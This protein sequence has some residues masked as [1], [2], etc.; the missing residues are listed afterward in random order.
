[1]PS[2]ASP[3]VWLALNP[4]YGIAG[5]GRRASEHAGA[6]LQWRSQLSAPC[7]LPRHPSTP[8]AP[9]VATPPPPGAPT[10]ATGRVFRAAGAA[11]G[12]ALPEYDKSPPPARRFAPRFLSGPVA[13]APAGRRPRI[14][15]TWQGWLHD[16]EAPEISILGYALIG[17]LLVHSVLLAMRFHVFDARKTP[18]SAP[19]LEVSLVNAKT[20]TRPTKAEILAQANL[21]GGGNTDANRRA[22]TPLPLPPKDTTANDIAATT[23][24]AVALEQRAQ[25]LMSQLKSGATAPAPA[26]PAPESAD[27]A[28][29]VSA[30]DLTQRTLEVMRLEAQIARD[31]D[32]YQKRPKRHA[33]GA[34][35]AEYRFARYVEDWRQ[36]VERV[37]NL[38]YP[39][40]ARQFALY[41]SLILTVSIRADGSVEKVVI[42]RSS[43]QK[44][45][46][47]AAAKIVEMA[48]PYAPFPPD[49]RRDTDILEITRTWTFEKG[50]ELRSD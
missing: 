38:N 15:E 8:K 9:A 45:L 37:G 16:L 18:D 26:T 14:R 29:V 21:D 44:V 35:A 50:N 28:P 33:V 43:G 40:A 22:K 13:R 10:P 49:I 48:G 17:S 31:M 42:D 4:G 47:A 5:C 34:R 46:D 11:P 7:L 23:Q 12:E 25:E 1:M 36:K 6:K 39:E 32:A 27:K 24:K 41:G 30:T 3:R 2:C 20:N 19:P